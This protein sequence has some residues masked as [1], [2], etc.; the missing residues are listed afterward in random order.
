[1]Q[2]LL[3]GL[4]VSI[5]G[6]LE[7]ESMTIQNEQALISSIAA[8]IIVLVGVLGIIGIIGELLYF[9]WRCIRHRE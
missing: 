8:S 9:V 2:V 4:A 3:D 5:S 1:M 6:A 7:V